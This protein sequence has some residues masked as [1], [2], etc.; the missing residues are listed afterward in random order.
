MCATVVDGAGHDAAVV[1]YAHAVPPGDHHI[2][3]T[4]GGLAA[5]T[6]AG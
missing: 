1:R 6:T 2:G 5:L 3:M 4:M